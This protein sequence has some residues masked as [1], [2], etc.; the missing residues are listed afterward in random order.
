M[1]ELARSGDET[2]KAAFEHAG[3][4]IGKAV[5]NL[6]NLFNPDRILLGGG[7]MDTAEDLLLPSITKHAQ[8]CIPAAAGTSIRMGTLGREAIARGAVATVIDAAFGTQTILEA[9]F[10]TPSTAGLGL[11]ATR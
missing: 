11:V 7:V 3:K 1:A 6:I 4:R 10:G 8:A 9:A 2:S 5:A